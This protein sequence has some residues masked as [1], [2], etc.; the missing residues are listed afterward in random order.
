MPHHG[1]RNSRLVIFDNAK[2]SSFSL[3]EYVSNLYGRGYIPLPLRKDSKHLDIAAMGYEPL[4]FRTRRKLLKE[5]SFTSLCYQFSQKPPT[6]GDIETWFT[7]FDGNLGILGGYLG[8]IILDFD[9]RAFFERWKKNHEQFLSS[10][11]VAQSPCGYHVFVKA[12]MPQITSS[13]YSGLHRIG[14]VK[15]L[16][17]YVATMPSA[18]AGKGQYEWL[19]NHSPFDCEPQEIES[20]EKLGVNPVSSL[21]NAYDRFL[22]RGFFE[23]Q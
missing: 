20:L 5:L 9:D 21:K 16:G 15:S 8:L 22:N 23:L 14:H 10:T 7:G 2:M 6:L 13:M 12:K 11:P 3:I 18:L 4:H 17:G 1:P 19:E